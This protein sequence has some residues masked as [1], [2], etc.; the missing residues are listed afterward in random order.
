MVLRDELRKIMREKRQLIPS[1]IA[2]QAS[3]RVIE[4]L[5]NLPIM[6]SAQHIALYIA[7]DGEMDTNFLIEQLGAAG[8]HCY[9]PILDKNQPNYLQFARYS[10]G[11]SLVPNRYYILEPLAS[12]QNRCLPNSLDVV[13]FPLVAFD[14]QGN[15]IG[16][17][18][19]YYDRTFE[20]KKKLPIQKPFLI[21]LAY[22][23]QCVDHIDTEAWDVPLQMVVTEK[24]Y[25]FF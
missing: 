16:M 22:E 5:L 19:G 20:F 2:Q 21:G 10:P 6:K 23:C 15:R 7:N 4:T 24:K 1:E 8:K 11:D 3:K 12:T 18:K 14:Q 13:L 25:Y 17:G 9:L